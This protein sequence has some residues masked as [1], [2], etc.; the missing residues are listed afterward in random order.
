MVLNFR[1]VQQMPL[2]YFFMLLVSANMTWLRTKRNGFRVKLEGNEEKKTQA[3]FDT[4]RFTTG[5]YFRNASF[6]ITLR[7]FFRVV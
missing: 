4:D 5:S 6:L 3:A 7:G 2:I 1:A